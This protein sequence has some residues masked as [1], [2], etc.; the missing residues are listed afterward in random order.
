MKKNIFTFLILFSTSLFSQEALWEKNKVNLYIENDLPS[1]TDDGYSSGVNFSLLYQIHD[2]NYFLYSL[3]G[4]NNEATD[5]YISFGLTNQIFT[6]T[7]IEESNLIL[8]DRPYASWS[9]FETS[10]HKAS[11]DELRSLSLQVGMVGPSSCGEQFQLTLHRMMSFDKIKGWDNQLENELGINLKYVQ[12]WRYELDTYKGLES[13]II[14]FASAELG[15]I[16]IN[17]QGGFTSRIGWNLSKDFGI[18]SLEL[19][20]DPSI[21]T[22]SQKRNSNIWGFSFNFTAAGSAIARDIFLDGNT[23]S[24][25][26]SVEKENFVGHF[27][28]GFS[29][30]YKDISLDF[31]E[32]V[33]TKQFELEK[34]SHKVSSLVISYIF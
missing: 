10:I 31:M 29:A 25:S 14:P 20:A 27:G 28:Y 13:V 3:L 8:N 33:S 11:K 19:G 12:K 9:Y 30:R 21:L 22:Y 18:S 16:A 1:G 4:N 34:N 15:N 6:P 17:A 7:N 24:V 26:H 32:T 2:E 23:F 5:S